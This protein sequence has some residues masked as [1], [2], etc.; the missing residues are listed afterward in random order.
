MSNILKNYLAP[1]EVQTTYDFK[2]GLFVSIHHH[3]T[4]PFFSIT[5]NFGIHVNTGYETYIALK[6]K[7]TRKLPYPYSNCIK[8]LIPFSPE[9][10]KIFP[11]F[12][13]LNMS[14][15]D[16]DICM[17]FCYQDKLIDKCD[18]K[19]VGIESLRNTSFCST[20]SQLDC[21]F[22]FCTNFFY[23]PENSICQNVCHKECYKI[24]Y[25]IET[26]VVRHPNLNYLNFLRHK[27]DTSFRFPDD[28][29]KAEKFADN[30]L[31]KLMVNYK[32]TEYV[33]T[34]ENAQMNLEILLS[35]IG[36][37][38]GLFIGI[39][40]VSLIELI[41]LLVSF[42]LNSYKQYQNRNNEH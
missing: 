27:N 26:N 15:Y 5:K 35:R 6:R 10:E 32:T 30:S 29:K 28:Q 2:N 17:S 11:Y 36:G 40:F 13:L 8:N 25:E 19:D 20:I 7:I 37:Q 4:T 14:Y 31:I 42:C 39:S 34:E 16:Q 22:D 21:L 12:A 41:E 3:N 24:E 18:C 33:Y 38:W 1:H 9:S 23:G